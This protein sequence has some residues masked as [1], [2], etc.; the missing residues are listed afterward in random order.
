[1]LVKMVDG[2]DCDLLRKGWPLVC[3]VFVTFPYGVLGQVW[4][5]VVSIPDRSYFG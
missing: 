1:M 4:Y 5:L 2:L 3:G